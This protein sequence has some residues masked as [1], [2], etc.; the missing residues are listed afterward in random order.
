MGFLCCFGSSA[1]EDAQAPRPSKT[2]NKTPATPRK[3]E[4]DDSWTQQF[5]AIDKAT[6]SAE[7]LR[8]RAREYVDTLYP[9]CATAGSIEE[10][11]E[12]RARLRDGTCSPFTH[13]DILVLD[14]HF[15]GVVYSAVMVLNLPSDA[16]LS[17]GKWIESPEMEEAKFYVLHLLESIEASSN[18]KHAYV[19]VFA[20]GDAVCCKFRPDNK[21]TTITVLQSGPPPGMKQRNDEMARS[22]RGQGKDLPKGL[23]RSI[24]FESALGSLHRSN[25]GCTIWDEGPLHFGVSS[26][27]NAEPT[28]I[29]VAR[30]FDASADRH[31]QPDEEINAAV[32]RISRSWDQG[33]DQAPLKLLQN[34]NANGSPGGIVAVAIF[35]ATP[36]N[37]VWPKC[38]AYAKSATMRAAGVAATD[39]LSKWSQQGKVTDCILTV[40]MGADMII[41]K[42]IGE[43]FGSKANQSMKNDEQMQESAVP[44]YPSLDPFFV[45]VEEE[46]EHELF[47]SEVQFQSIKKLMR[48]KMEADPET[49]RARAPFMA[50]MMAQHFLET[51]YPGCSVSDEGEFPVIVNGETSRIRDTRFVVAKDPAKETN[52]IIAALHLVPLPGDS[53]VSIV[54]TAD[55]NWLETKEMKAAEEM[56]LAILKV[57]YKEG[58]LADDCMAQVMMATDATIYRFV[59]GERFEDYPEERQKQFRWG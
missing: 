14:E 18:V 5:A 21:E 9:Q 56:L 52:N 6:V 15:T 27:H 48:E 49:H 47:E 45:T 57:W 34:R 55:R 10:L 19:R 59:D 29:L 42:F 17:P 23:F 24:S 22:F 3:W 28:R 58:R 35:V 2:S 33:S 37:E 30:S 4:I 25:P 12:S 13:H 26:K 36:L 44:T 50:V 41:L 20:G 54:E 8:R 39:L 51:N 43:N 53:N 1:D 40:W 38:G 7:L 46:K 32:F 16:D 31:Y 11:G